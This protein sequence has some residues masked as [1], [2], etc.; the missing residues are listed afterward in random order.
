M[1]HKIIASSFSTFLR[2]LKALDEQLALSGRVIHKKKINMKTFNN[3]Y[4]GSYNHNYI[5]I[6][7]D[8]KVKYDN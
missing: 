2:N 5:A 4:S 8:E 7:W 1:K 6:L 3:D